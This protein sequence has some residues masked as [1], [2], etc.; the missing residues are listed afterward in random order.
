M[1]SV[2]QMKREYA[3]GYSSKL[4]HFT[5]VDRRSDKWATR[6]SADVSVPRLNHYHNPP[7]FADHLLT[8][9]K[10]RS[11]ATSQT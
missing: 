5:S 11:L 6:S 9:V 4:Y 8:Y 1:Q 7:G 3:V 10:N 2:L